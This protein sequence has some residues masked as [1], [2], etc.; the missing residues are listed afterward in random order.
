MTDDFSSQLATVK[1]RLDAHHDRLKKVERF[2]EEES[3][4]FHKRVERFVTR[5]ETI[6]SE[7]AK[8]DSQRHQENVERMDAIKVRNDMWNIIIAA[9]GLICTICMLYLA[10]KASAH[11]EVN[12][13]HIG[14]QNE[15]SLSSNA[16]L[17]SQ[18]QPR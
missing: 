7:R 6:E 17:P 10:V 11:A 13:L 9:F 12:P 14:Q 4:E 16:D 15:P 5:Y 1:G 2:C 18:Y 8:R 3:P